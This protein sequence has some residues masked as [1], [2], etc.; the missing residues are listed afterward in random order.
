MVDIHICAYIHN[1]AVALDKF[2]GEFG[3][4]LVFYYLHY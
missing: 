2:Q 4:Y 1:I 3:I